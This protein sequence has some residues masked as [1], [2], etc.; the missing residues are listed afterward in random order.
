MWFS[1]IIFAPIFILEVTI[2]LHS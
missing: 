1:K 2:Y